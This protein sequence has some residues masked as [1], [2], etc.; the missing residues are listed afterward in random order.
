MNVDAVE[1]RAADALTVFLY[2]VWTAPTFPSGITEVAALAAM[3]R[4][5]LAEILRQL[6]FFVRLSRSRSRDL[7]R[8]SSFTLFGLPCRECRAADRPGGGGRSSFTL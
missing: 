6:L 5:Y 4:P 3:R 1:Q 2:F 7:C 8:R